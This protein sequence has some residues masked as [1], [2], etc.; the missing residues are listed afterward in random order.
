MIGKLYKMKD[1][2]NIGI[3]QS[4]P[5]FKKHGKVIVN[6]L[7]EDWNVILGDDDR[8]KTLLWTEDEFKIKRATGELEHV[9]YED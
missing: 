6:I 3:Y 7:D 2:R 5:L 8:P 1:G 4:Q 9:G